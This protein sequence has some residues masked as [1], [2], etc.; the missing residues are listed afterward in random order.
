MRQ[1]ATH[2]RSIAPNFAVTENL[3]GDSLIVHINGRDFA[4]SP[5]F[6]SSYEAEATW[7]IFV[8]P[9]PSPEARA[10]ECRTLDEISETLRWPS[11]MPRVRT[12]APSELPKL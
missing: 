9:I 11:V 3:P 8:T 2:V 10:W 7:P 12:V 4:V 6:R 5:P 1:V